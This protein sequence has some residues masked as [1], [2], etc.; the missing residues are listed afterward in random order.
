M[1]TATVLEQFQNVLVMFS[2]WIKDVIMLAYFWHYDKIITNYRFRIEVTVRTGTTD[3]NQLLAFT[4]TIA[5]GNILMN[6]SFTP[7]CHFGKLKT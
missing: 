1:V 6:K 4:A 7:V 5:S 2:F 3:E